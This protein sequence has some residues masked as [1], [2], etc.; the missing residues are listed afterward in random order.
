MKFA[1]GRGS[2]DLGAGG[3]DGLF[4]FGQGVLFHVVAVV[5]GVDGVPEI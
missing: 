5:C 1:C 4:F 2:L 3:Q